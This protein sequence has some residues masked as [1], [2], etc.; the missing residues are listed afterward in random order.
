MKK[1]ILITGGAGFIGSHLAKNFSL[2]KDHKIF[3][4][5]NLNSY[6]DKK[7]KIYRLRKLSKIS[8]KKNYKFFKIDIC[9][10]KKLKNFFKKYKFQKL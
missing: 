10:K 7:L 2:L 5:D 6:Y 4:I 1:K 9:N 3:V 8:K